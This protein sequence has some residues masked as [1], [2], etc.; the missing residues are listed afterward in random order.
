M[1]IEMWSVVEGFFHRVSISVKISDENW[2]RKMVKKKINVLNFN[3]ILKK[4]RKKDFK[5]FFDEIFI[6]SHKIENRFDR[7]LTSGE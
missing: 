7:F 6:N 5:A 4:L 1:L 2:P 3:F